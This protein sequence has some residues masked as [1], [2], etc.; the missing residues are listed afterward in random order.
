MES[1]QGHIRDLPDRAQQIPAKYRD[2][3]WAKNWGVDVNNDFEPLYI[4]PS[5]RR[6]IVTKLRQ[7]ARDASE[8]YLATDEDREG[9]AIAW[10]LTEVLKPKIPTHRMVFHEITPGAITDALANPR[11]IDSYRVDAQE[12]RRTLDRLVGYGVSPVLW[13]KVRRGLSAGRVQSVAVRLLVER[14]RR[15]IAFPVGEFLE[16]GGPSRH[17]RR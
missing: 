12:A 11:T 10:H 7:A 13:R 3:P 16:R 4:V 6:R 14:E 2:Q 9:E 17:R 1:C 8:L 5:D 15:R